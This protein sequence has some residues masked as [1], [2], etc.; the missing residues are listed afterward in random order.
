MLAYVIRHM[1]FM[2]A[3][4]EALLDRMNPAEF[5]RWAAVDTRISAPP[6]ASHV[7]CPL[8]LWAS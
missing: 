2:M 1:Q 6:T 5:T 7:A 8:L 3:P 4:A